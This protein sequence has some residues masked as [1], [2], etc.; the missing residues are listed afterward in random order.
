[1][2]VRLRSLLLVVLA[3]STVAVPVAGAAEKS[4]VGQQVDDFT[5]RDF[6]GREYSLSDFSEAPY[7]V[8]TFL[9]NECP[10]AKL[11][12]SRLVRLAKDYADRDVAFVAINSN[13]QDTPTE[14]AAFAENHKLNFPLLKDAGNVVADQIGAQRTPEV[15]VLD[16]NRVIRYRGRI[17]DQYGAQNQPRIDVT[18]RD[19]AVALDELLAGQPVSIPD[20]VTPGCIIGRVRDVQPQ[21]DITY[22]EHVAEILNRR[23]VE[24]HREG[25]LAPFPLTS[26]EDVIGWSEM[27]VEVVSQG[28]MPPWF[29]DPRYGEFSN[30]CS[31]SEEEKQTLYTWVNN[32]SPQGDPAATPASPEFTQGWNIGEPDAVY[33]MP[34]PYT[35]QADGTID[36]QY[37][38]IDPQLTEDVWVTAAEARPDNTSVVHHIVLFALPPGGGGFGGGDRARGDENRRGERDDADEGERRSRRGEG[39]RRGGGGE[40]AIAGGQLIAI[41]APGMPAWQYP[42][43]MALEVKKG[44]TF[45]IQMHY[46]A[47]GSEQQDQ[48]YIGLKFAKPGEVKQS[49]RNGMALNVG[50]EIPPHDNDY[51]VTSKTRFLRNTTL[52]QL[53]PHMHYR[54]KA[55]K[56]EAQYPDGTSEVL[57]DVPNYDFNWQLRYDLAEPKHLPRGTTMVCTA[58]YDNSADNLFNPDPSETVGFGLQSF[59]EMMVGYYTAVRTD[60]DLT[61]EKD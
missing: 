41:Y 55:F 28:R 23:C 1:M 17:D 18:R 8:V 7:V 34:E 10:L 37:F 59:E 13:V 2:D 56:F 16:E 29:A 26:Y 31:M 38:T 15:F 49:I 50:F 11:Y 35:V 19:L 22:S 6:H 44:S 5:L 36:Y 60:E 30:D 20:T 3:L 32:G 51:V 14:M 61:K 12:A 40:G 4:L 54:G 24:C 48:S 21:G 9:G 57:L 43:G 33:T 39:R 53:F 58:H 52:L 42:E 45:V 27:I 25:E 47:C 46:T